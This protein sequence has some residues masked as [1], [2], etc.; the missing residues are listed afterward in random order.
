MQTRPHC[1]IYFI[2]LVSALG[3]F[4][5]GYD[6]VVIGGAKPFYELYFH[7]SGSSFEQG[8]AMSI[9]LLG[10]M[11][12]AMVCGK[13]ADRLGRKRL[14]MYSSLVFL[15]SAFLTA[16]SRH[17]GFFLFARAFCGIGIGLASGLSPM[18]IAEVS[19]PNIRGKL[20]SLNQLT[21]VLGIL[22]AQI[23]NWQTADPISPSATPAD[24]LASW[25]GQMAWRW[26]FGATTI[27]AGLFFV[28][29]FFIPESPRWLLLK[30][31]KEKAFS[32]FEKIGGTSYASQAVEATT[33]AP[34]KE[35]SSILSEKF[36]HNYKRILFL[37]I[38]IAVFQQ[39]SGTNVIFNYAQEIFQVAGYS[40]GDILFNIVITGI[41]NVVFTIIAVF[42]IDKVGRRF[43]MLFGAGSLCSIYL[44]LGICYYLHVSGLLMVI[45]VVAAIACYAMTLG[46]CTWVLISELYPNKI[47]A[48]AVSICTL[49][50]WIGSCSLT[51]SFPF[52]NRSLGS[53]GT[54]WIYSAICLVG[55]LFFFRHLPETKGKSLEEIEDVLCKS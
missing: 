41:A 35:V 25:N 39:W 47:R 5:F 14:L 42:I 32:I 38:F 36:R 2:C 54:F 8:T 18:Y 45:L 30:G 40:V 52:L 27:P 49:V 22:V 50:L 10:C 26:M 13:L 24:I 28:L 4:L 29:L 15:V 19:P 51:F 48:H 9:A 53:F 43:L 17:F 20:V 16:L 3:G 34:V 23:I 21:I 44:V 12:G 46:P 1:Y 55:F 33:I 37:G 6:W 11:I 31:Q 7:I